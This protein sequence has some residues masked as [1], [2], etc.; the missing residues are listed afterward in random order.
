MNEQ[1]PH[2]DLSFMDG[3]YA[4][5]LSLHDDG[6]TISCRFRNSKM[7]WITSLVDIQTEITEGIQTVIAKLEQLNVNKNERKALNLSLSMLVNYP[8][9]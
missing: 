7:K 9:R 4:I 6:K 3:P 8:Q 5:D 2:S 1:N